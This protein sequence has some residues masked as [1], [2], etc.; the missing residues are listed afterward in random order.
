MKQLYVAG[1]REY[2]FLENEANRPCTITN[3]LG[4]V[5]SMLPGFH[6]KQSSTTH[7]P[8]GTEEQTSGTPEASTIDAASYTGNKNTVNN[9]G[10]TE[11]KG[12]N[13]H[14]NTIEPLL[15]MKFFSILKNVIDQKDNNS[16][17]AYFHVS[18]HLQNETHNSELSPIYTET[19][20]RM[21]YKAMSV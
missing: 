20:L 5:L 17:I 13:I 9:N 7:N 16:A 14:H 11:N 12:N 1:P 19:V 6:K 4:S 10:K 21:L 3:I 15:K 2:T 8:D 18:L